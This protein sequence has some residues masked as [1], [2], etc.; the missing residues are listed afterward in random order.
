MSFM[1]FYCVSCKQVIPEDAITCPFC[2]ADQRNPSLLAKDPTTNITLRFPNAHM[3]HKK[4]AL[5]ISIAAI[6]VL[7]LIE[8]LSLHSANNNGQSPKNIS[9]RN[10]NPGF[11]PSSNASIPV[12]PRYQYNV[13][14]SP[15]A[16]SPAHP[17]QQASGGAAV[18]PQ[19][20]NA[21]SPQTNSIPSS[22]PIPA[23]DIGSVKISD[24]SINF[25]GDELSGETVAAGRVVIT[26]TTNHTV[27]SVKL[28][29]GDSFGPELM[30][31][32]GTVDDPTPIIDTSIDPHSSVSF[33][34]KTSGEFVGDVY[35]T[36]T[37]SMEADMDDGDVIDDSVIID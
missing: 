15:T 1:D 19:A 7:V 26:N 17:S 23:P 25:V 21:N 33:P 37:V 36:H 28:I 24:A 16:P 6:V 22:F 4:R 18:T 12:N 31:F 9:P 30:P 34:V 29:L 2:G 35:G 3:I 14:P 27:S 20:G 32:E 5:T 10:L 11:R 8:G 13:N